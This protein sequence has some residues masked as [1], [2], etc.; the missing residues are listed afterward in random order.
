MMQRYLLLKLIILVILLKKIN[1]VFGF[2]D[3]DWQFWNSEVIEASLNKN[4]RI[5]LEEE[6][7]FGDD[8]QQ[9]Y[10]QHSDLGFIFN[11]TK[12]WDFSINYRQ[13]YEKKNDSWKRENRPHI[14]LI[15]K[16]KLAN[17]KVKKRMRLEYR[18]KEKDDYFR[19]RDKLSINLTT[20]GKIIPYIA[21]EIYWDFDQRKLN[22]NRLYL[23]LKVKF[24]S[25][26]AGNIFYLW[27]RSK[28]ANN[29][30][31]YNILGFKFKFFLK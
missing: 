17:L 9:F 2:D 26:L 13:I 5:K 15:Y 18:I 14:N 19:Y 4:C 22:R 7:R 30:L 23:G 3:G 27:Q 6:F 25:K 8:A 24:S 12:K 31:D 10:Y 20:F 28:K 1:F 11:F 21:D 29:W 16:F